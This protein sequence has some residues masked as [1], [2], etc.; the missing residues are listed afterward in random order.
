MT[1]QSRHRPQSIGDLVFADP[2]IAALV[3]RYATQRPSKPLLL[4]GPP[5]GGKS[6]A[7]RLI[8]RTQFALA[9]IECEDFVINGGKVYRDLFTLMLN[10][11]QWQFWPSGTP[12]IIV[13]DEIDEI[14]SKYPSKLRTFVEDHPSVQILASTNY[15]NR[16]SPALRSR[17][18]CAQVM[19]PAAADWTARAQAI[20][21][22]EGANVDAAT[23]KTLMQNF[24]GDARDFIDYLEE[25]VT[26]GRAH[27]SPIAAT[28]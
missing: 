26:T 21:A 3:Q 24:S 11:A 12:G 6:E 23:V 20:L 9:G 5:G 7:L 25:L 10:M 17:M 28:P 13:I 18:R 4:Y 16:I 19:P 27:A 2:L 8:A 14:E 1:F 15:F 22:A